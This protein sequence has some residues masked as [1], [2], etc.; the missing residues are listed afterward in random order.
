M[1]LVRLVLCFGYAFVL[2]SGLAGNGFPEKEL[3][4]F[5]DSETIS[6]EASKH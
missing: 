2:N 1:K 3:K 5:F 6:E 4:M